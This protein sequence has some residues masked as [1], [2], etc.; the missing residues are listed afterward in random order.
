MDGDELHILYMGVMPLTPGCVLWLLCCMC[1]P[2]TPCQN[3]QRVW[4]AICDYYYRN[5]VATR[6]SNISLTL[7]QDRPVCWAP[8]EVLRRIDVVLLQGGIEGE[9]LGIVRRCALVG[10]GPEQHEAALGH[11][12]RQGGHRQR[13]EN[14]PS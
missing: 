2:N 7:A 1:L 12:Q 4:A 3:M 13:E 14:P 6:F 11:R 9:V 10:R 8:D 5:Q